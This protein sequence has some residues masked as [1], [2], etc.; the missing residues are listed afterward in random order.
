M[1]ECNSKIHLI[2]RPPSLTEL[3][4]IIFYMGLTHLGSETFIYS[5][6]NLYIYNCTYGHSILYI[7]KKYVIIAC[8]FECIEILKMISKDSKTF[9]CLGLIIDMGYLSRIA[10]IKSWIFQDDIVLQTKVCPWFCNLPQ[11]ITCMSKN[12]MHIVSFIFLVQLFMINNN[13]YEGL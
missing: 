6:F 1:Q 2:W 12:N 3:T 13:V 8:I 10:M 7:D 4:S 9:V 5:T 11:D